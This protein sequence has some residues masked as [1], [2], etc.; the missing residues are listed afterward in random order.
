MVRKTSKPSRT[1]SRKSGK[2]KSVRKTASSRKSASYRSS[3]KGNL[4]FG[5]VSFM[6]EA[7]NA[8]DRDSGEIH[9]HQL[10]ES[11]HRRIRYEKVC[12][13]HGEVSQDEIV[14]G[15]E[16]SKGK[17]VVIDPEEMDELKTSAERSLMIDAFIAPD[18]IDPLYFDGRMYYLL[19]SGSGTAEPYA[20]IVAAMQQEDRYAIGEII[21]S[22]KKQLAL[23][24][25]VEG[26]LHMALLNY[27]NEIRSPK[28]M[29]KPVKTPSAGTRQVKMAQSLVQD[30]SVDD[31]DFSQFKDEY[32]KKVEGLIEAR[33]RGKEVTPPRDEEEPPATINLM[34]ALKQ[35]MG[36][37]R[38]T[39]S[40][41]GRKQA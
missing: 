24:R 26:V 36:R 27:A 35:S 16:I 13:E 25:P 15:Y 10:H 21:M 8:H 19:P 1:A 32:R 4:T 12:P 2:R 41:R 29:A 14:S 17:Y 33:S 9:F 34:E 3:W 5:L 37:S 30:W 28:Q 38:R 7:V 23:I 39:K 18:A 6:V 11:C 40:A 20:V 31:F 22:G